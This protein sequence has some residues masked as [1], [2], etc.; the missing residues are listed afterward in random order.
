M[1]H[2]KI[3]RLLCTVPTKISDRPPR[4]TASLCSGGVR[5]SLAQ[6]HNDDG[7]S[8]NLI[9]DDEYAGSSNRKELP[10]EW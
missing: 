1:P 6:G 9:S 8:D 5:I 2:F 7:E 4:P 10:P 3:W